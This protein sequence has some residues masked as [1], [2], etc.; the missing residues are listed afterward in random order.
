MKIAK[1]ILAKSAVA[2]SAIAG[3]TSSVFAASDPYT[4]TYST[5]SDLSPA[6]A[7]AITSLGIIPL[8]LGCCGAIIGLAL[9]I[10]NIWMLIDVLK[11]TEAELPNKTMYMVLL[12]V[13]LL[14]GFG[15]I[16]ALVYFFGPRKKFTASAKA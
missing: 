2:I 14:M 16:P 4:Y 7:A 13:G 3:F 9:L 1:S 5:S 10:L 11:R 12:I 15:W 8:V 6:G